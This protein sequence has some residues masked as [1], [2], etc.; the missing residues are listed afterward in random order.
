MCL[1]GV[2]QPMQMP[3]TGMGYDEGTGLFRPNTGV[4]TFSSNEES[5]MNTL[6]NLSNPCTISNQPTVAPSAA[7]VSNFETSFGLTGGYDDEESAARAY[8]LAALKL[9]GE[10][11]ALNF[12]VC[13]L[14]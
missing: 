13:F 4:G 7:N 6:F 8:D 14:S 1:L 3:P 2:L 10:L 12:P 5:S 9:W 11:A